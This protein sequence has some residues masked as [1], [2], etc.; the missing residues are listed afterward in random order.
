MAIE[1]DV[2]DNQSPNNDCFLS[3]QPVFC[4]LLHTNTAEVEIRTM[5]NLYIILLKDSLG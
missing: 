1:T 4:A 2:L 5:G 3:I